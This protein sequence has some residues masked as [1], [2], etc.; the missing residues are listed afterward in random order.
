MNLSQKL[1]VVS[2][3]TL[4]SRGVYDSSKF[5]YN[6]VLVILCHQ[7]KQDHILRKYLSNK[8]TYGECFETSI[9]KPSTK[10]VEFLTI[11]Y[12]CDMPHLIIFRGLINI[13]ITLQF[14][15]KP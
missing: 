4:H 11:I 6:N 12:Q 2:D 8:Q 5:W 10:N 3:S 15:Q 9:S 13:V 1:R 14:A 7:N